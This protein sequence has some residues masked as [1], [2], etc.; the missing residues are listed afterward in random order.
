MTAV[1]YTAATSVLSNHAAGVSYDLTLRLISAEPTKEVKRTN[2]QALSGLR[3]T[4]AWNQRS[5]LSIT[6]GSYPERSVEH[7]AV[8]EFLDSVCEGDLFV[9][10]RW[11]S[12]GIPA[13]PRSAIMLDAYQPSRFLQRSGEGNDLMRF[14]FNIEFV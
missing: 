6:I 12:A 8:L 3:E 4:L 1:T 2:Q 9:F 14:S 11:G 5:G 10:D 7:N 13:E